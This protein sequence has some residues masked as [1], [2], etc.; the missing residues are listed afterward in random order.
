M[1]DT[2][3]P[4]HCTAALG[5]ATCYTNL[6]RVADEVPVRSV[7]FPSWTVAPD[8]LLTIFMHVPRV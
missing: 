1:M 8:L 4:P 7:P 2:G 6:A 5:A 3:T